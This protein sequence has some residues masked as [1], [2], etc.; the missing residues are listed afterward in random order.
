MSK[1]IRQRPVDHKKFNENY[2]RIFGKKILEENAKHTQD[3]MRR[4]MEHNLRA[5]T[6]NVSEH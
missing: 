4:R 5:N 3:I 1:G 2:D 6:E